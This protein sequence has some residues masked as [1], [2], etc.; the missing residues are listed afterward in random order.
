LPSAKRVELR[1]ARGGPV[2][3]STIDGGNVGEIGDPLE[4]T[5]K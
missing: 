5:H 1:A 4:A 2:D 3:A